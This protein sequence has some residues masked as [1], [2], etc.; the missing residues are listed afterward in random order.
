MP[1]EI[2]GEGVEGIELSREEHPGQTTAIGLKRQNG[3][4]NR[5]RML[6]QTR[7]RRGSTMKKIKIKTFEERTERM[8]HEERKHSHHD[9]E[10]TARGTHTRGQ[11]CRAEKRNGNGDP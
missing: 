6:F 3:T 11:Q 9:T 2:T 1:N 8:A 5:T 7:Q 10:G 4:D